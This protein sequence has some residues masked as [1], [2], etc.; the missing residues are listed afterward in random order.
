M[1]ARVP[2]KHASAVGCQEPF[3]ETTQHH[4]LIAA[5]SRLRI[6]LGGEDF[7]EFMRG[8]AIQRSTV[9]AYLDLFCYQPIAHRQALAHSPYFE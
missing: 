6:D 3:T 9:H 7:M 2:Y 5:L 8:G 1:A 4:E